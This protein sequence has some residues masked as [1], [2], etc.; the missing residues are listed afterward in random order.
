M[1]MPQSVHH[2]MGILLAIMKDAAMN[3]HVQDFDEQVFS[4]LLDRYLGVV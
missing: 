3:F 1:G 2:L 4:F